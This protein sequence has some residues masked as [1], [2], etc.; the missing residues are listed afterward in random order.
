MGT[1]LIDKSRYTLS[2][3]C[4]LHANIINVSLKKFS[5]TIS[6]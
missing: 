1:R 5:N 6:Q 3:F 4:Y 2:D